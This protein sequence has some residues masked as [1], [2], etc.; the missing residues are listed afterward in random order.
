MPEAEVNKRAR[1]MA[2]GI[3]TPSIL[4]VISQPLTFLQGFG[5][6]TQI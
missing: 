4:G 6:M 3:N 5:S 1:Q 2:I